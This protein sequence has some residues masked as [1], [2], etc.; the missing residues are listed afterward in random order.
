[1]Y[2]SKKYFQIYVAKNFGEKFNIELSL[3]PEEITSS[4]QKYGMYKQ[5]VLLNWL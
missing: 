1:V 5:E 4:P 3:K 2:S